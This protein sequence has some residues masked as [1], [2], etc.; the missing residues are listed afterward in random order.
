MLIS[1]IIPTYKPQD[2]IY[3]CLDSLCQQTMDTQSWEVIVVLNG[4][5]EPWHTAIQKYATAHPKIQ[6]HVLQTDQPGVSNARNIGLDYARGEYI[7][8]IDDDDYVSNTYLASLYSLAL[9]TIVSASYTMAVDDNHNHIVPPYYIEQEYIRW[10]KRSR[11][12][13]YYKPRRY[14]NGACMKLIHKSIIGST[15]FDTQFKNGEDSL[16]MF[17]ISNRMHYMCFADTNAIYYRRIR[18]ESASQTM[19]IR[20]TI[21]NRFALIKQYTRIYLHGS[22]Y[23]F[24]FYLTRIMG[25]FN[26]ILRIWI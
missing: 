13:P 25:A 23:S 19:S 18:Q 15:R 26:T 1:V 9:P 8:F 22:H 21:N 12:L 16:F 24:R 14:M 2:Y 10:T 17:A 6:M 3:Q 4:C 7:T 20:Q 11:K 5:D